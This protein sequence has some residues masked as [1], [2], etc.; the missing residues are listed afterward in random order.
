MDLSIIIVNYNVR[1]YLLRCLESIFKTIN[2]I[3]FE[4]IVIDNASS[5]GS[6]ETVK[7]KYDRVKIVANPDNIGFA[8]ANNQG[9]KIAKGKYI[10]M[11]NPDTEVLEDSIIKMARFLDKNRKTGMC[12]AAL[13]NPD[14]SIQNIGYNFP[15]LSILFKA[16]ILGL[17]DLVLNPDKPMEVDW[18]QG[19]CMMIRRELLNK[20]GYFDEKFFIY[21]EEK[22]F[23][24]RIKKAG[25]RIFSLPDCQIIHHSSKS[26]ADC[27]ASSF[28]EYHKSQLYFFRKHYPGYFINIAK[29]IIFMGILKKLMLLKFAF[30]T[31]ER[32]AKLNTFKT[33]SKW[34]IKEGFK[35]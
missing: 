10:L 17:D 8:K 25:W 31:R 19:S 9:L 32:K 33:V 29:I 13:L 28:V 5:D 3:T 2:G 6:I 23:C 20:I 22:D 27:E 1:E 35:I 14:F 16:H 30:L 4:V 7:E 18:L 26:T 11:L 24:F 15:T 12:G 21:G 34:Y